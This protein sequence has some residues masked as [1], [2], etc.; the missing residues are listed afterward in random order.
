MVASKRLKPAREAA[1]EAGLLTFGTR[2]KVAWYDEEADDRRY[3]I[4]ATAEEA[5]AEVEEYGEMDGTVEAVE[6]LVPTD[7]LKTLWKQNFTGRLDDD[8]AVQFASLMV[9]ERTGEFDGVWW[10]EELDP[11]NLSAP[12]GVIFQTKLKEWASSRR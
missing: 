3:T 10:N 7:E 9:L 11:A 4:V 1:V 6:M 12:R 5:D 2:W 8:F